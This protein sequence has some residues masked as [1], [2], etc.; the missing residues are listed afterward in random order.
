MI[1]YDEIKN[2]IK[3]IE[4]CSAVALTFY[5]QKHLEISIKDDNSPVTKADLEISRIAINKLS[6]MFPNDKIISEENI[7]NLNE[8]DMTKYWLIDPIDGTKEFITKSGFFT[9]NFALISNAKP[10]FGIICQP[11]TSSIWFNINN[12]AYKIKKT[13]NILDA[14]E[15]KPKTINYNKL[16][17]ICSST[18]LKSGIKNWLN[19]I[20]PLKI[21]DIGSSLKFCYLAEGKYDIYPRSIPTMELSLIHI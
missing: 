13:Y 2:I 9:I 5:K 4:E 18:N 3:I 10:V 21:S 17:M 20:N 6:E 8:V 11:T 7:T 12:K 14:K 1:K 15:L 19:T 16:N